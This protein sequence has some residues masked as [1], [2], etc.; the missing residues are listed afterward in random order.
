MVEVSVAVGVILRG[1]E[2][3]LS[4][5][6]EHVHQG[7]KWEFPGGKVER[8]ESPLEAL[9]RELSEEVGLDG[10]YDTRELVTVRHHYGDKQVILHVFI[11]ENFSSEPFGVE[12]QETAW[13][14]VEGL[15]DV[16][17]PAAN[18]EI[19][20]ALKAMSLTH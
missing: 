9:R 1:D 20:N 11:V 12:Q 6:P 10:P 14:S 19:V 5:R 16:D 18:V 8:D 2:V 4:L 13:V 3:F 17:L 7:G 15:D